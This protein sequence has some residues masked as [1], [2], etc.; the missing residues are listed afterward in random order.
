MKDGRICVNCF[1]LKYIGHDKVLQ[2]QGRMKYL[3]V[4]L[5]HEFKAHVKRNKKFAVL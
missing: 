2:Q 1:V 5:C 3:S 4:H